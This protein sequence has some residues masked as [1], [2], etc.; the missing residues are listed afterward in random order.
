MSFKPWA[1]ALTLEGVNVAGGPQQKETLLE[2]DSLTVNLSASSLWFLSPVV[3]SLH[4]QRPTLRLSRLTPGHYDIDD[5]LARFAKPSVEPKPDAK[6]FALALYNISLSEGALVLDDRPSERRHEL[7]QLALELPFLST[8]AADVKVHVQPQIAGRLNGVAF[9]AKGSALPFADQRLAALDFKLDGLDLAPYASYVPAAMPLRLQQGR[10]DANLNLKFQQALGQAPEIGLAGQI[11]LAKFALR[12]PTGEPALS[13]GELNVQL[14]DVQPLRKLVKLGTITWVAPRFSMS[15]D[16]RGE[17]KGE[18]K[19][20]SKSGI[21][22]TSQNDAKAPTW[23][24]AVER[25]E[26]SDGGLDWQDLVTRPKASLSVQDVELKLGA[27]AWPVKAATPIKLALRLRPGDAT[28]KIESASIDGSGSLS[29]EN[30]SFDW[31]W[32][33]FDLQW[34]TPYLQAQAP[35]RLSG[36]VKG[37]GG[38][39][40]AQPLAANADQ[41][42][43]LTLAELQLSSLSVGSKAKREPLLRL[44]SLGLDHLGVDLA[45][46]KMIAGDLKLNRPALDLARSK[47]GQWN[48]SELLAQTPSKG[49]A[50]ITSTAGEA[51]PPWA[52]QLKGLKVEQGLI[53]LLDEGTTSSPVAL[54][55]EQITLD[56]RGLDWPAQSKPMPVNFSLKLGAAKRGS[57]PLGQFQWQGKAG[58]APLSASGSLRAERLPLHL[59]N[60]YLDP[61][62]GMHLQKAELGLRAQF[63]ARQL[64]AGLDAQLTGKVLL[65]DLLLHQSRQVD[66]QILVGEELLSWQALNLDGLKLQ[67]APGGPPQI[68]VADV[69]LND[70]FARVII[71]EQGK[72]NLRDFGPVDRAAPAPSKSVA[73]AAPAASAPDPSMPIS[74]GQIRLSKGRIDFNDRFVRPNYSARLS[75]LQGS[76]GAFS[77]QGAELAPLSLRGRVAGTGLLDVSGNVNPLGKPFQLD[78]NA[79]ATDIELAP[80]SPYAA[81]YVGYAIE[82]GKFSSKVQYKIDPGGALQ[83]NN[84]IILNQLTFGERVES[85][86]ATKL[87]VLFAVALLKDRDGVIDVEVPIKGSINEPEFSVGGLIWKVI[88]N[89]LGKAL[90]APF[91]LFSGNAGT[92]LSRLEFAPGSAQASTPANLDNVAKMM[93]E[94]PGLALT[95]KAWADPVAER[96]ALQDKQLEA[97]LLAERQ[98]ELQRQQTA[99]ATQQAEAGPVLTDADRQ[100]LL[101]P[102]YQAAKLPNKPKNVIG[103][104]KDIPAPEMRVLLLSSYEVSDDRVRALAL[105]RGVAVRDA[106]IAKGLA[107]SRIFLGAPSLHDGSAEPGQTWAPY[108]EM[109]LSAH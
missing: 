1:L 70:F 8:L 85:P 51:P 54:N 93:A 107:N 18:S 33:G 27:L 75:E 102:V 55:A 73:M 69:A 28:G 48:F 62:W 68:A 6:P 12:M 91:S 38:L 46:R 9:S 37:K 92:D 77:S 60:A 72:I 36:L 17:N 50:A 89:L 3:E 81:K 32:Q 78:I 90:T 29:A 98:R 10:V 13:W 41:R 99:G 84:Q 61:A 87:P 35:L 95:I 44:A 56:L 40:L 2:L 64:P 66:G 96:A 26:L 100:R 63:N 65:A 94:R 22:S 11:R 74:I 109:Q 57:A 71:N 34:L 15:R 42:A 97:A 80:L 53:R 23:A 52:L 82:R 4:I 16:G 24:L 25:F 105:E 45:A 30:L 103:F 83:A 104:A 49:K 7:T 31:Q 19:S 20:G 88:A 79:S 67:L 59:L 76:L 58:L 108:A 47:D 5:L 43:Q 21:K 14:L 39:S 86:D 106:L 101:K